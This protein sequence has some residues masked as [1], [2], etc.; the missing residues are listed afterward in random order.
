MGG[1]DSK[2]E[3]NVGVL[4]LNKDMTVIEQRGRKLIKY[5]VKA[6][7]RRWSQNNLISTNASC[8]D[9]RAT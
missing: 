3:T 7:F 5:Q 1:G 4:E 8:R 2:T 6:A 9:E